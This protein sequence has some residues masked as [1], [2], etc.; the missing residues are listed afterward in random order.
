MN[1]TLALV[2]AC[3]ALGVGLAAPA[4]TDKLH[5]LDLKPK[6]NQ[7]LAD[8][9]GTGR[10]GN[11]LK[12]LP[13]GEQTFA[14][15]KFHVGEGLIQLGSKVLDK[16]PDKVEG[17]PVGRAFAKLHILHATGFGGGPNQEGSEWYV[18]DG[19]PIGEYRV[20]YEGGGSEAI[21]IVYGE[22]VRDWFFVE[23]EKGVTR[24]KVAWEGDND[25]AK[26]VGARLRLYVTSWTNPKPDKKV[27]SIDYVSRK[28]D[29]VAAPVCVAIT[30]ERK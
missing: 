3:G 6:T 17:I 25:R 30:V 5:Y 4:P 14:G 28:G 19:T 20:N 1:R 26:Q 24:G 15:V 22:D 13:A 10:E 23:G 11:N 27:V 2:A 16:M 18:K 8:N 12:A 21:P 9:L 7:K 29:T